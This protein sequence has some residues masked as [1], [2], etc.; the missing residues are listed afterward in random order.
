MKL[1]GGAAARFSKS[2]NTALCGALLHG[3]D[4]GQV[5]EA[6][7]SMVADLTG[8]D[9]MRLTRIDVALARRDAAE[10]GDALRARGFFADRSVV[11]IEGGTDGL[12][13][14]LSAALDGV[15]AEDAFLVVTADA[16]PARSSLRKLF[17][18]SDQLAALQFFADAP[19]SADIAARLRDAGAT[20]ADRDAAEA[21]ASAGASM[22]HGS[23]S[24]LIDVVALKAL[25]REVTAQDVADLAPAGMD[26]EV[27]ALVAAVADG[28]AEAIGPVLR[29]LDAGGLNVV[30][31]LLALQRHFRMLLGA[32]AGNGIDGVRP[33][34]YGPRKTAAQG[35]L[36]RWG[37]A[38][39][40]AANRLLLDADAKVR[41]TDRAP[42]KAVLERCALRLALMAGR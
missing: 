28:R 34:L 29:R 18:G 37:L 12:A 1:T 9:D 27:D 2:P 30:T 39:L 3:A 32:A 19:D 22:D 35:Q 15:T 31:A 25:G 7:R 21:L 38:R 36:R 16:L 13:K 41:S 14:P 4:A 5:V 20:G 8:G 17:E 23:F 6:R 26:A 42:D 33:P 40:E 11:L 24:R 10:V